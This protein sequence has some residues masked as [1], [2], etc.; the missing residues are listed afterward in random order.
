VTPSNK[1]KDIK[2]LIDATSIEG[3]MNGERSCEMGMPP[4][5]SIVVAQHTIANGVLQLSGPE[6][7]EARLALT[8]MHA[9]RF[10]GNAKGYSSQGLSTLFD[11]SK[12]R[13]ACGK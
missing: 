1:N 5:F 2:I 9:W 10:G 8:G 13:I 12:A 4:S 7:L 11:T 6:D 3:N